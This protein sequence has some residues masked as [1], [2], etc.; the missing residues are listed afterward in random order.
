MLKLAPVVCFASVVVVEAQNN[1]TTPYSVTTL[2]GS[3]ASGSSNG[4]G[5]AAYFNGPAGVAVDGSGYI[6]VAD[7]ENKVVRRVTASGVVT[8][9][10]GGSTST[11][12]GNPGAVAVDNFGNIFVAD[13]QL[14]VI[15]KIVPSLGVTI[16]A[17]APYAQGGSID[18]AGSTALFNK[19]LGL[20]T[21]AQGNVYVGDYLNHTIRKITPDGVVSTFAGSAGVQGSDDGARNAAHFSYPGGLAVDRVG[22]VYVADTGNGTIRK[23]STSGE[24]NTVAGLAG[25]FG[26]NDGK[27]NA[28]RFNNPMGVALDD[29][30]NIYVADA[31]NNLIRR[32]SPD[33][34][35]STLAGSTVGS[36]DGSGPTAHFN[37]PVAIAVGQT[38][39]LFIADSTNNMIRQSV[40]TTPV[41]V[42]Q[43]KN[44]RVATTY[45]AT[46]T[47][48][49][50][51]TSVLS[52]QWRK[53]GANLSG[54]QESSYSIASALESDAGEYT[55]VVANN[56]GT[57]VSA[58]A[59]LS[60][61][62]AY[63]FS[64]FAGAKSNY[65]SVDGL[66][67]SALFN[68]PYGLAI[69]SGGNL[70]VADSTNGTIRKVSPTGLVTTLAGM[71]GTRS[72]TDGMRSQAGFDSPEGVA[73]DGAGTVYVADLGNNT[74]RKITAEG[75]VTT[76]AGT[77]GVEGSADG[78]G[79]AAS[80]RQ[81]ADVTV[82]ASGNVYVADLGNSTVR[83]ITPEGLVTT[84]A[85]L[86]GSKG[87]A[88]GQGSAARF[89]SPMGLALDQSGNIW[90]SD[91]INNLIRKITPAG[92]VTT[93]A[94][95]AGGGRRDSVDG[96][97]ADA[98]FDY[99]GGLA[100]NAA[101]EVFVVEIGE[102]GGTIRKITPD[103]FVLTVAGHRGGAF[104]GN[105]GIGS[106]DPT[107]NDGI[108]SAAGFAYP[109][110]VAVD[111]SGNVYIADFGLFT[112]R[113][114]VANSPLNSGA[115]SNVLGDFDGDGTAD[116]VWTNTVTGERSMWL[117]NGN[118][119]KAGASL[120][121]VPTAWVIS[122]TADF[123]GDGKAD[124]FWTNTV[125]G[126][127]AIWL[128]DGSV[129]R[130]NTFMGTVPTDWVISG[131]GDFDG[132]GKQDLVWTNTTTGDRAMWLLNGNAVKG[133]GYL[134]TV[135]VA[136]QISGV[137]DFNGDGKADLIWS[138]TVTGEHSMWFQN[139]STTTSGATLNTV[140]V[141]WVISGVG[142]FNGDGKADVL[143][144][145]TT[146]GDRVI[147]LM[148]GS[149]ITTNAF[150]G[151]VPVDWTI[152]GTGDF[153]GDGKK[154]VVWTN[155]T[156]G[157]R[158]MW[159]LN[160]STVTGGGYLGTVPVQWTIGN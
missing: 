23:I 20:A 7:S 113:R 8:T 102:T 109:T 64:T 145:N 131:T 59:T 134:G 5:A 120:G 116:L 160:G 106:N 37:A 105:H 90:V 36:S 19:P 152:S 24:V 95:L 40:S 98:S 110:G 135:P 101:G 12:F 85:G 54:A 11:A 32:I 129:M 128:M 25:N 74:V 80:F 104:G 156:T 69:D 73:V 150:M 82:D 28:A 159:L 52:Y 62:P 133:G 75:L 57:A 153:N 33:G 10:K 144:T 67:S 111:R 99:I 38:G 66:G 43:P 56:L 86:P 112:L 138:N 119:V 83:K 96:M 123:D 31:G 141:A 17:G 125:T 146:S 1:Y 53:N 50:S 122:A 154:D 77:A 13:Y 72:S 15:W 94:G 143:L 81:P 26:S 124:I 63:N 29:V 34:T 49:A 91:R 41:I 108:G 148:N 68:G 48:R 27:G 79:G 127:R 92:L 45:G 126:D 147:W 137:G 55:V 103:G 136:W 65:G 132:D 140:P 130:S 117:M 87:N 114:G 139:G 84:L 44:L 47:V 149:T 35:V 9:V 51:G 100:V 157:D 76:L 115:I 78:L 6:F 22:N 18:G 58:P 16:F 39:T 93:V 42:S 142:D 4:T 3:T 155:T 89:Y 2:A 70:Y 14:N 21:D 61:E 97:L 118:G 46:F 121:V 60:V 88:D 158:A 107:Y 30:G 151:T 71:A